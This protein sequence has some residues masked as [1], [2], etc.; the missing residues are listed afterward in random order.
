[1]QFKDGKEYHKALLKGYN[2]CE[3]EGI[4]HLTE[5]TIDR[6]LKLGMTFCYVYI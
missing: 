6:K 2:W 3:I 4:Q 1:M 5:T